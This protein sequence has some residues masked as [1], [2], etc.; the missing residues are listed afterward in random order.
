M[1]RQAL[2]GRRTFD[3]LARVIA[4]RTSRSVQ[5]YQLRL[6][7]AALAA[8]LFEAARYWADNDGADDLAQLVDQAVTAVGP[9]LAELDR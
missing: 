6:A 9:L 2:E 5:D 8:A 7:A 1:A 3:L 4:A